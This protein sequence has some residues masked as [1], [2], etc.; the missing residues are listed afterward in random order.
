[1][2]LNHAKYIPEYWSPTQQRAVL[3][4]L[5]PI[6]GVAPFFKPRMPRTNQPWSI[7]MTNA[8]PL[9]WVS[10]VNGYRYQ[11][12]HPETGEAWPPLPD[13]LQAAWSDLTGLDVPQ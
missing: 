7:V 1:M 10:D 13:I 5:M 3:A 9:G 8:G 6:I 11:E 2:D 12:V 4:A